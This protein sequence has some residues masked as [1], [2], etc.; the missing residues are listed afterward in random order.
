MNQNPINNTPNNFSNF[1]NV[2]MFFYKNSNNNNVNN[3]NNIT[4]YI[5]YSDN[6]PINFLLNNKISPQLILIKII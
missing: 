4:S 2:N 5:P 6:C 3:N 1:N